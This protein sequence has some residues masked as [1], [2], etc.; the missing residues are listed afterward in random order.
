[1]TFSPQVA[2]RQAQTNHL[3]RRVKELQEQLQQVQ[4]ESS[5]GEFFTNLLYHRFGHPQIAGDLICKGFFSPGKKPETFRFR[6]EKQF[7]SVDVDSG[8]SERWVKQIG[9]KNA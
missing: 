1:M 9:P 2:V 6:N 3:E 4:D 7:W 5:F 8:D